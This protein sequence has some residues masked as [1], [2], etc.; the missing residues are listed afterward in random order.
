MEILKAVY[1]WIPCLFCHDC[2]RSGWI[3][4]KVVLLVVWILAKHH[5]WRH[6]CFLCWCLAGISRCSSRWCRPCSPAWILANLAPTCTNAHTH[7]KKIHSKFQPIIFSFGHTHYKG[8]V[9]NYVRFKGD[10]RRRSSDMT[11]SAPLGYFVLF[12]CFYRRNR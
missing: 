5:Q 4:W 3:E 7:I 1:H 11:S 2:R 12:C 6:L 10:W 8:M 9:G